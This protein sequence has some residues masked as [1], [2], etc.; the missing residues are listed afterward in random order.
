MN[1]RSGGSGRP[2]V[3]RVLVCARGALAPRLIRSYRDLGLETVIAF[4]PAEASAS[5]IEEADFEAWLGEE[6]SA[7]SDASRAVSA[8][9]DAGCDGIHPG[10]SA[11]ACSLD[12]CSIA[13]ASYLG[14]IGIDAP[15]AGE[16]LDAARVRAKVHSTGT[17]LAPEAP[18]SDDPEVA[19]VVAADRHGTIVTLGG[20]LGAGG[21][22][23]ELGPSTASSAALDAAHRAVRALQF[24]GVGSVVLRR[25]PCSIANCSA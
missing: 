11:L 6:P 25:S 16:L 19:V 12:L 2:D 10:Y 1:A 18:D 14:V 13:V 23:A 5:Y 7:W 8:A 17:L 9:L 20:L 21:P 3:R 22:L 15:R 24:A 4:G